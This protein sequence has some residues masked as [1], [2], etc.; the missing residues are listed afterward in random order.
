[1]AR[2]CAADAMRAARRMT[3]SSCASL[4]RR[5]LSMAAR[6][7]CTRSGA[8][9]PA[10]PLGAHRVQPAHGARVPLGVGAD[11]IVQRRLILEQ[12]DHLLVERRDRVG[13]VEG[14]A[15]ARGL[16]A[17]AKPV[18]DLALLVALAAE[19]DAAALRGEHELRLRLGEA[20]E[21]IEVAVEAVGE[22][23]VAVAQALGSG[24][25]ERHASR[26]PA[27]GAAGARHGG[28]MASFG[29]IACVFEKRGGFEL[30]EPLARA[31]VLPHAAVELAAHE[32]PGRGVV[33]QG[34]ERR[35]FL[36]RD[37]GDHGGR[38]DGDAGVS[39]ARPG[40]VADRSVFQRE[41]AAAAVRRVGDQDEVGQPLAE[42]NAAQGRKSRTRIDVGVDEEETALRR[43][44]L[45]PC[46]PPAVSSGSR[47]RE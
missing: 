16:R 43:A 3:A 45:A 8:M 33:Q 32:L 13:L 18:P 25:H 44:A 36:R 41:V 10:R 39:V 30:G 19:Q 46:D 31:D 4:T 21:V 11:G 15:L 22:M 37:A 1:M 17:V 47:S 9:M 35:F 28:A 12:L 14:E 40:A 20:A 42:R 27:P 5:M 23:R 7:S 2:R 38:H 34:S 26:W 29:F 6:T 24:R